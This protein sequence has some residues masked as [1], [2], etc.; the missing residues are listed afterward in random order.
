MIKYIISSCFSLNR[1]SLCDGCGKKITNHPNALVLY[2][3]C[4]SS[5]H[6]IGKGNSIFPFFGAAVVVIT[7]E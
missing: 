2:L 7:R 4:L 6:K 1:E 5:T 3:G